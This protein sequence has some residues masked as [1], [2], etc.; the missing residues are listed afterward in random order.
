MGGRDPNRISVMPKEFIRKIVS[1]YDSTYRAYIIGSR[2]DVKE[3]GFF[4]GCTWI[5]DFGE[6]I[7]KM[8]G[9]YHHYSVNSWTKTFTGL[10]GIPTGIYPST[11]RV[12]PQDVYGSDRDP[13]DHVFLRGWGFTFHSKV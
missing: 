11:Y 4:D 8:L 12:D 5:T 9:S 7:H 3:Y 10:M 2:E 13:A 6:C 1:E